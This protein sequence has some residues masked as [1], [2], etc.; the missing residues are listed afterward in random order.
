MD[1][2]GIY[3]RVEH[4][5]RKE[6]EAAESGSRPQVAREHGAHLAAILGTERP[7]VQVSSAR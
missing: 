1:A 5:G 7:G 3:E 4:G 2:A 6:H